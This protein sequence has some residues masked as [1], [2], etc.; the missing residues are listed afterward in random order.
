MRAVGSND[1]NRPS[2]TTDGN[3]VTSSKRLTPS[4][5]PRSITES[6]LG[7]SG[8]PAGAASAPENR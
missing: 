1:R 6:V 3:R 5:M 8:Q 4:A 7:G 2:Y